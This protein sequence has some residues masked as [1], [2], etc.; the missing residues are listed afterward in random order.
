MNPDNSPDF[1]RGGTDITVDDVA[2]LLRRALGREDDQKHSRIVIRGPV[3]T[4]MASRLFYVECDDFPTAAAVKFCLHRHTLTPDVDAAH[5]QHDALRIISEAMGSDQKYAVPKP[6][7]LQPEAGLIAFEWIEGPIMTDMLLAWGCGAADAEKLMIRAGYW[8]KH[9]H[10]GHAL[11]ADR[12]DTEGKLSAAFAEAKT[13]VLTDSVFGQAIGVLK[14]TAHR[15]HTAPIPR[16]W[17][18]GDFKT[19]NLMVSGSRTIGI[20]VHLRY[21]NV[22]VYDLAPFLNHLELVLYHPR[23][24]RHMLRRERLFSAFLN[25]YSDAP[26]EGYAGPLNWVRL[27]MLLMEWSTAARHTSSI[28]RSQFSR[29]CYRAVAAR[30]ARTL[31]ELR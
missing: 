31:L 27:Y 29:M 23:G 30:L 22:I 7:L 24:W 18:H 5:R 17:M 4:R 20:D 16:S 8:L 14:D 28:L 26:A 13:T 19:D 3:A 9:F 25:A 21:E 15:V 12:V 10:E 2:R 1:P 6:Y 11:S